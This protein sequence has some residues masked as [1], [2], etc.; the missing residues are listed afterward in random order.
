MI[1]QRAL[2]FIQIYKKLARNK[3]PKHRLAS[4]IPLD[5]VIMVLCPQFKS[6]DVDVFVFLIICLSFVVK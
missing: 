2:K 4:E 5:G 3:A 1:L 6:G